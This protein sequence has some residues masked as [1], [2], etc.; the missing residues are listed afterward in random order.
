MCSHPK[1]P[2]SDGQDVE[3]AAYRALSGLAVAGLICGLLSPLWLIDPMAWV[4]PVPL[5][6]LLLSVL[7]LRRIRLS[8][9]VL[10]G[11]RAAQVGLLLCLLSGTAAPS[12]WLC[13]RWAV[14]RE[15]RRFAQQWFD[16]LAHGQPG[17]AYQ[18]TQ[19]PTFRQP[20]DAR[21]LEKLY[22][23]RSP[24]REELDNYCNQ[25]LISALLALGQRAQVRYYQTEGV[26]GSGQRDT[27]IQTYAVTYRDPETGEKK[28][29]FVSLEL[30]RHRFDSG[31]AEWQLSQARDGFTPWGDSDAGH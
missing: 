10:V 29:F 30:L 28:S 18:L 12:H 26:A 19:H 23:Q 3:M 13:Y 22:A 24:A 9:P 31:Q 27:V 8:A 5:L 16:L 4:L 7:A 2:L 15:A 20:L 1:F 6:G 17:K 11:R 21:T 14:R 25:G